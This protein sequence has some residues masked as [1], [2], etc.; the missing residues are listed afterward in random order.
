MG[1]YAYACVCMHACTCVCVCMHAHVRVFV[2]RAMES[3]ACGRGVC[4]GPI[5]YGPCGRKVCRGL[6]YPQHDFQ[7]PALRTRRG[8]SFLE[9]HVSKICACHMC[10]HMCADR[11]VRRQHGPTESR[12]HS[13]S[14]HLTS[15]W[16]IL[17]TQ[18]RYPAYIHHTPGTAMTLHTLNI[19][20]LGNRQH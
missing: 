12:R 20:L 19:V 1:V 18:S 7:E 6:R 11:H 14:L 2:Q 17:C 13:L 15:H 8:V 4:C 5:T 3:A 10:L 9:R 16:Q